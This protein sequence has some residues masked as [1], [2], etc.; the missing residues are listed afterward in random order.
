MNSFEG[1]L[2]KNVQTLLAE[3]RDQGGS[4]IH[5]V[6]GHKG[7]FNASP[8]SVADINTFAFTSSQTAIRMT[9]CSSCQ[10]DRTLNSAVWGSTGWDFPKYVTVR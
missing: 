8:S 6:G 5:L 2:S 1:R 10:A 9:Y 3:R 7:K 4:V